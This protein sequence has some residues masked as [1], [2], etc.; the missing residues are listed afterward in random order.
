MGQDKAN[1][2][3][4]LLRQIAAFVFLSLGFTG[5]AAI[6]SWLSYRSFQEVV[7][8]QLRLSQLSQKIIYFD[9]VLT[10]SARVGAF[11]GDPAWE[12]RYLA[13]DPQLVSA[14]EEAQQLAPELLREQIA[15]TESAN[16]RLVALEK[17]AFALARQGDRQGVIAILFGKEYEDL[18]QTYSQSITAALQATEQAITNNVN[19]ALTQTLLA[20]VLSA[21]AFPL[22]L[23][24]W[25]FTLRLGANYLQEQRRI[26]AEV[27]Q[28]QEDLQA[29]NLELEQKNQQ[30]EALEADSRKKQ[31]LLQRRALEL[32]LEVD[33]VSRGD[34]T[35]RATVTSDEIGTIADSYNAI[36]RSLSQIVSQVQAAA[37]SLSATAIDSSQAVQAVVSDAERQAAFIGSAL[38]QVEEMLQSIQ[39]VALRAKQ[40]EETVQ[41]ASQVVEAGD[42]SADRA[43]AGITALK[44]TVTDTARKVEWL[45][46]S[47]EKITKVVKVIRNFAA[48]TNLLALN[49]SIEAARAGEEGESFAV[50]AEKV[51]ALAQQS[52]AATSEIEATVEEIQNQIQEVILAMSTVA[53]QAETGT[54][55]VEEVRQTLTE[56][57]QASS[58]TNKLVQEIAQAASQQTETSQ[59]VSETMHTVA[60]TTQMIAERS[61]TVATAIAQ[62]LEL[63]KQLQ[64]SISQFKIA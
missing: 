11:T 63:A 38:S 47:S 26:R 40:A 4:R 62:L 41:L 12:K 8:T 34:L 43:L 1:S 61:Q 3:D 27:E 59:V 42:Q 23:G 55:L 46:S 60:E 2:Q 13:F 16:N 21:I 50:V 56:I 20:L 35:V 24:S 9:E 53:Q 7:N 44:S 30:L 57:T 48:Q 49:A 36:I 37:Q 17:R 32:L 51:R 45:G 10:M 64:S 33:P 54:K 18:K 25:L 14:L 6:A 29:L 28:R 52:A 5:I 58:Q 19:A 31:E 15:K 22:L 39:G